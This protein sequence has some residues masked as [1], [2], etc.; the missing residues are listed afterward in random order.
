MRLFPDDSSALR[1][2]GRFCFMLRVRALSRGVNKV[3]WSATELANS[4]VRVELLL[5]P[6]TADAQAGTPATVRSHVGL[7][8]R[9]KRSR[10]S[11]NVESRS[12]TESLIGAG[13]RA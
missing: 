3:A 11:S 4:V 13:V 10:T 1:I 5:A 7:S 6:Q 12:K 2:A 8:T 9:V